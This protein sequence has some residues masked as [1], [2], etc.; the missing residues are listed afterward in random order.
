MYPC[1]KHNSNVLIQIAITV[2]S[3]TDLSNAIDMF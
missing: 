3:P 1:P 2:T